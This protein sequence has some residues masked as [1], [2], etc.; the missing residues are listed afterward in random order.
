MNSARKSI[1]RKTHNITV[2]NICER[3][4]RIIDL[5][6]EWQKTNQFQDRWFQHPPPT[7][8]IYELTNF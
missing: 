6:I 1:T 8:L 3:E 5:E 2:N 4:Y 7:G